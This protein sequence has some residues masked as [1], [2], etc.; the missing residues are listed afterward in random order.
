M[1]Y[2]FNTAPVI[3]WEPPAAHSHEVASAVPH[4]S[5]PVP[6]KDEPEIVEKKID[7]EVPIKTEKSQQAEQPSILNE[8]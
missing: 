7:E 1:Q 6:V 4:E 5:I 3:T 8:Q 2:M